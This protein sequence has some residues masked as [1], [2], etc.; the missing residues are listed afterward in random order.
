MCYPAAY[1]GVIGVGSIGKNGVV[2][3][4][5]TK[6]KSVDVVAP[7]E[8]MVGLE[9][10]T[11]NGYLVKYY[12]FGGRNNPLDGTSFAA[13]VVAAAAA[14]AKQRD[15]N[16]DAN[17]FL[18]AL[19]RTSRDAGASGYDTAYGN[20]ILDIGRLVNY[21]NT[22]ATKLTFNANGGTVGTKSK[23][24]WAGGKYGKLPTPKR[25]K[26]GFGGWYTKKT[27]GKRVTDL[28]T[29][30]SAA[31]VTL[32]AH[33]QTGTTLNDLKTS[34]GKLSPVFSYK[35]K[36]YK[37]TLTK[38]QASAKITPAKS[39]KGAKMSIKVGSGKYKTKNSATV[40]LKRG[41]QTTVYVKLS[42]KGIKTIIYKIKVTRKK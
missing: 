31:K 33:W 38:A 1:D 15:K 4:F 9:Y 35:K 32:Y 2:S 27:G 23:E 24:V 40:K 6:N 37:L 13:P 5:S 22:K 25:G 29:V 30:G 10:S 36:S 21:L 42:K 39:Y 20:G 12:R 7:G 11:N 16:I 28:S 18:T 8:M 34:K 26:Y 14:M 3:D 19:K 41:K 17:A